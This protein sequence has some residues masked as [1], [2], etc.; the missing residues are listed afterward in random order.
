M[1]CIVGYRVKCSVPLLHTANFSYCTWSPEYF[2]HIDNFYF[3]YSTQTA[4]YFLFIYFR[5][6]PIS[7]QIPIIQYEIWRY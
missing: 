4:Y 3:V 5:D 1:R 7:P 2:V 6:A